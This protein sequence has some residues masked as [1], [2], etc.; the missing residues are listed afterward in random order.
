M[1]LYNLTHPCLR[2]AL[3]FLQHSRQPSFLVNIISIGLAKNLCLYNNMIYPVEMS[4]DKF[5]FFKKLYYIKAIPIAI[6]AWCKT[7]DCLIV[8]AIGNLT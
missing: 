7:I 2:P 4:L 8:R 1:Y 3:F 5:F 6:S